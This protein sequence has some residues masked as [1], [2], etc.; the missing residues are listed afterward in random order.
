MPYNSQ[1]LAVSKRFKSASAGDWPLQ[2]IRKP[3][4]TKKTGINRGIQESGKFGILTHVFYDSPLFSFAWLHLDL[5]QSDTMTDTYDQDNLRLHNH[6]T[7]P[8]QYNW[9]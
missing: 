8:A 7:T 1:R 2:V 6:H 4:T 5:V 9:P 3:T